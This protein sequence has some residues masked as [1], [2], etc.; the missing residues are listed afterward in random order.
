LDRLV[1]RRPARRIAVIVVGVLLVLLAVDRAGLWVAERAAADTLQST[2]HL[3]SRPSVDIGGFPFLNQLATGKY[4]RITVTAKDVPAGSSLHLL[5]FTR[6]RVVLHSL[7]VSRDFRSFHAAS[8]S[9]TAAV[10]YGD[11]GKT[12]GLEL[13]YAGNGRIKATK[14]VSVAGHSFS[15]TVTTRPRLLHDTL[16]FAET[17][18]DNAGALSE[19]V[20]A[21]LRSVFNFDVPL[22]TLPFHVSVRSL[23]VDAY[24]IAIGLAGRDLS[25]SKG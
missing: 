23:H 1:S 8:A 2:E 18:I 15:A 21:T 20:A 9:A 19:S 10:T 5:V 17:S 14:T 24:G 11:L 6:M 12:L 3:A 4:D 7:S 22:N 25:Y 13:S 16:G